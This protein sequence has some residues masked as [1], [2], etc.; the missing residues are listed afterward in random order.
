MENKPALWNTEE[1]NQWREEL[2]TLKECRDALSD[3]ELSRAYH[4]QHPHFENYVGS[5]VEKFGA[6]RVNTVLGYTVRHYDYDGRF[7]HGAK[8]WAQRQPRAPQPHRLKANG[9]PPRDFHELVCNSHPVILNFVCRIQME[10]ELSP[11]KPTK[12]N[13]RGVE[14]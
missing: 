11:Q 7:D 12:K 10:A 6:E 8:S 14:R 1:L 13:N 3:P 4:A 9:A 5:V 2:H